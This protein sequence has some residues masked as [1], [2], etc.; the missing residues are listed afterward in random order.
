MSS[1]RVRASPQEVEHQPPG[2]REEARP[3]RLLAETFQ[4]SH[5]AVDALEVQGFA[6]HL[7]SPHVGL[8]PRV[9]V[10]Q[11]GGDVIEP[12]G[13]RDAQFELVRSPV[14]GERG[15]ETVGDQLGLI[16]A[17]G[18]GQSVV[19]ECASTSGVPRVRPASCEG[20]TQAGAV[21]RV[22]RARQHVVELSRQHARLGAVDVHVGRTEGGARP[23]AE[24][25]I[26][27]GPPDRL[28]IERTRLGSVAGLS[29]GVSLTEELVDA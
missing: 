6:R 15:V 19:C 17:L 18:V 23:E 25:T 22:D 26:G 16:A 5:L 24:V 20:R 9:D 3:R 1:A 12:G 29:Q 14:T 8:K 27:A 4:S 2:R 28:F 7:E 13:Q 10:E 11:V 21:G